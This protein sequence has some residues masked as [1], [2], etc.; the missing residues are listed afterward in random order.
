MPDGVNDTAGT[1]DAAAT[2]ASPPAAAVLAPPAPS[3]PIMLP[4]PFPPSIADDRMIPWLPPELQKLIGTMVLD[5]VKHNWPLVR[6]SEC[7]SNFPAGLQPGE[8][9]VFKSL[10]QG[11]EPLI[12]V[13]KV[14]QRSMRLRVSKRFQFQSEY[15]GPPEFLKVSEY[16]KVPGTSYFIKWSPMTIST[17]HD[18]RPRDLLAVGFKM[19]PVEGL[20][21]SWPLA[22]RRPVGRRRIGAAYVMDAAVQAQ[23]STLGPIIEMVP[24][25]VSQ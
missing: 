3:P 10:D 17:R 11:A 9:V 14:L 4:L 2:L 13:G 25:P 15:F 16:S 7:R 24:R 23:L 21:L 22:L 5:R 18:V 8:W 19:E 12:L 1:P 6:A 20:P